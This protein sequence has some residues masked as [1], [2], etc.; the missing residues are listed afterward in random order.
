MES[1]LTEDS[2]VDT[3]FGI[4]KKDISDRDLFLSEAEDHFVQANCND[5][6]GAN[7]LLSFV[8]KNRGKWVKGCAQRAE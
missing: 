4:L 5:R 3:I 1:V 6:T 2:T 8:R 7:A